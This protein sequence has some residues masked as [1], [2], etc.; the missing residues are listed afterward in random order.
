M[1]PKESSPTRL[2]V[3]HKRKKKTPSLIELDVGDGVDD[4]EWSE[5]EKPP[6]KRRKGTK[7]AKKQKKRSNETA[8]RKPKN[9]KEFLGVIEDIIAEAEEEPLDNGKEPVDLDTLKTQIDTGLRYRLPISDDYA[10]LPKDAPIG[11]PHVLQPN[12]DLQY[13][14]EG[15]ICLADGIATTLF[16][17]GRDALDNFLDTGRS[18][19]FWY[20]HEKD[21]WPELVFA[22]KGV[23]V[24]V[25]YWQPIMS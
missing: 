17:H 1:A 16:H 24:M 4:Q 3:R 18:E 14:E 7:P 22:R 23:E 20:R 12:S 15:G 10:P 2:K 5:T 11:R 6:V 25:S 19:N 21:A 8:E 13:T 9:P